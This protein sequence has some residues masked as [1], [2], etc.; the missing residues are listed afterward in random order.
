VSDPEV[1]VVADPAMA[2][3]RAASIIGDALRAGVAERGRADWATTGG[4]TVTA[5]YRAMLTPDIREAIPWSKAHTWWGDDRF[6]PGDHPLS[7]A[8]P[9]DDVLLDAGDWESVHSDDRRERLRIPVSNVH[10]F[11]TGEAI[12]NGGSAASCASDLAIEL[13]AADLPVRDGWPVFDLVLLGLGGDGHVLSVFP[14][15]TTFDSIRWAVAVPAPTHIEPHVERVTL[16]P[17][18]V[19]AARRV[20]VVVQ[21]TAKAAVVRK[22]FTEDREPRM[23]PGQ[24]ALRDGATWIIDEAAAA[25]LPR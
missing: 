1:V 13:R 3:V 8:K 19:T 16:N 2:A 6:V 10:P 17:A 21:G 14:G 25:D 4:S 18:T 12:G 9:F 20:V 11:R 22:I 15:S 23:L 5:I 7:N 24:L